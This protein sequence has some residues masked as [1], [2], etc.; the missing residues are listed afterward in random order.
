MPDSEELQSDLSVIKDNLSRLD[1]VYGENAEKR[2]FQL[3][4]SMDLLKQMGYRTVSDLLGASD[5]FKS[6]LSDLTARTSAEDSAEHTAIRQNLRREEISRIC[7]LFASEDRAALS[8]VLLLLGDSESAGNADLAYN[9]SVKQIACVSNAFTGTFLHHL[10]QEISYNPGYYSD[11]RSVCEAVG[12][13]MDDY[14]VIPLENSR[15]GKIRRFYDLLDEYDLRIIYS[16]VIRQSGNEES[17]RLVLVGTNFAVPTQTYDCRC[18]VLIPGKVSLSDVLLTAKEC[19]LEPVSISSFTSAYDHT[20]VTYNLTL[21]GNGEI[22][23]FLLYLY[24]TAAGFRLLGIYS[25]TTVQD[26]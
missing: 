24:L 13:G 5:R 25:Q 14:G 9:S 4:E 16:C 11:F 3:S 22:A 21:A 2:L 23:A 10:P 19:S 26:E 12:F 18:E 20:D 17:H 7:R 1:T 8:T 6:F 15:D